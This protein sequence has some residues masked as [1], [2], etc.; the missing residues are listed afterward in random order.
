MRILVAQVAWRA[1]R[2]LLA[3]FLL[4]GLLVGA[5]VAAVVLQG[6]RDEG[7][8][9]DSVVIMDDGH[10]ESRNARVER[11]L[12]L[13][14]NGKVSRI[15]VL[16]QN[17]ASTEAML[18][19]GGVQAVKL[20]AIHRSGQREQLVG[21]QENFADRPAADGLLIA[22]PV[23]ML[24]LLKMAHDYH[25]MLHGAPASRLSVIDMGAVVAE[26]GRYFMYV[27]GGK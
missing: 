2:R 3:L 1:T 9:A 19:K 18:Q 20:A 8:A 15:I 4:L 12:M 7:A 25:I 6:S 23:E 14:L 17:T 22:E 13:Y 5:T 27:M 21:L 16:G 26:V 10:P 11:A 24:R